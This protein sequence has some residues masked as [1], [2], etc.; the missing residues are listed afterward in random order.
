MLRTVGYIVM[1]AVT[2]AAAGQP[3][4][5]DFTPEQSGTVQ[6]PVRV[7]VSKFIADYYF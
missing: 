4:A 3:V 7:L 1:L 2:A 6:F 5:V